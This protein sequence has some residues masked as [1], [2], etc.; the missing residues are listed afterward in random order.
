[1]SDEKLVSKWSELLH[2]E[3][4][5]IPELA[6]HIHEGTFGWTLHHPLLIHLMIDPKRC[7]VYNESYR[8]K[9]RM[10]ARALAEKK[11]GSALFLHE[12][13]YRLEKLLEYRAMGLSGREYW[14]LVG[15]VW[16]D[17]ENIFQHEDRWRRVWSERTEGREAVMN[18]KELKRLES[19]PDV[20]DVWR[21]VQMKK[22]AR[23]L[24]WTLDRKRA[25]WFA[26]RL[27]RKGRKPLLVHGRVNINDVL[28][29]FLGRNEDEVVAERV[30]VVSVT[31][32][33]PRKKEA[34]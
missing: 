31:E 16:V 32:L 18:E 7:A 13:P 14:R 23:G 29:V 6:G 4:E 11:W 1:M 21:G 26:H 9:S 12:R 28:A 30:R 3:E 20:I 27:L 19:L 5:A 8:V 34:A 10:V 22:R 25:E 2:K 15:E 24:S 33:P 17:S